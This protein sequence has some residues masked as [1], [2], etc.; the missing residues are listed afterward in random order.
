MGAGTD[1]EIDLGQ[2]VV[3]LD[4]ELVD[5]EL[6]IKLALA[7]ELILKMFWNSLLNVAYQTVT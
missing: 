4:S 3:N 7:L 5:S 1:L 6:E 2:I